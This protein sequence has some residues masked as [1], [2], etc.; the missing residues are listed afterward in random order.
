[1]IFFG[2][3]GFGL[4]IAKPLFR[5]DELK[6][7]RAVGFLLLGCVL[8]DLIDKPL[9]HGLSWITGKSGAELGL[10]S[11]T[12]TFGHTLV[13][14]FLLFV[15]AR[16]R[17]SPAL[18]MIAVGTATH[19]FV[20]HVGDTIGHAIFGSPFPTQYD[21]HGISLNIVGLFWPFLGNRFPVFPFEHIM[22][23][24]D[25]FRRPH[26]AVGEV[27]GL[28]FLWKDRVV[29]QTV[30]QWIKERLWKRAYS[31]PRSKSSG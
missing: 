14:L 23:H 26:I 10:I 22:Q 6:K 31:P 18:L 2:H 5:H 27:L 7:K 25:F 13:F 15:L 17:K 19:L 1:M 4:Q 9:Y 20:D 11:T 16:W 8:P 30:R 3:L 21:E 24:F 12:R 28:I 29:R